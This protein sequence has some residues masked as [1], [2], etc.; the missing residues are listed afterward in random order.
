[1]APDV[2]VVS[3]KD[4]DRCHKSGTPWQCRKGRPERQGSSAEALAME[5]VDWQ[6]RRVEWHMGGAHEKATLWDTVPSQTLQSP[7]V[8]HMAVGRKKML[9]PA[10]LCQAVWTR[11]GV[12]KVPWSD[13]EF[14]EVLLAESEVWLEAGAK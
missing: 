5:L 4:K 9:G 7:G 1:V 6:Q 14:G 13:Q 11:L 3:W 8:G 10:R 12:S 2:V